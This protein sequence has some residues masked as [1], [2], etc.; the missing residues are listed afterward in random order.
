M[1]L[2]PVHLAELATHIHLPDLCKLFGFS[3]T[4]RGPRVAIV[5]LDEE[6]VTLH[7]DA[8]NNRWQLAAPSKENCE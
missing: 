1:N 2:T 3:L 5:T 7:W 4:L 8:G 6:T